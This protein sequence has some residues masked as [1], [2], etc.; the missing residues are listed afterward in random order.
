MTVEEKRSDATHPFLP[1]ANIRCL[2]VGPANCGKTNLL[3]NFICD[4]LDYER[5][6]VYSNTLCQPK[7][8]KLQALF[9]SIEEDLGRSIAQFHNS[10]ADLIPPEELDPAVR[11][12]IVFD[13]VLLDKQHNIERYFAQGRHSNADVFYCSQSYTRVPKQVVRDNANLLVLFP[14]D[15]LNLKHI[16]E[17]HAGADM[18]FD[19]FKDMCRCCW[20][21]PYGF[22]SIDKTKPHGDGR[23]TETFSS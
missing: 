10:Q 12:L 2:I 15:E 3:F 22:L 9:G 16:Y 20:K 13:D 5:L 21:N 1:L 4:W 6:Y 19:D 23:Y 8:Q 11:N 18:E 14:Q 7:Y 17:N